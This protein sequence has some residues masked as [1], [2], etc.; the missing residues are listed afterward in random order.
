VPSYGRPETLRDCLDACLGLDPA[1]V[2]L[3]VALRL[4]DVASRKTVARLGASADR[5]PSVRV[6]DVERPGHLPPL[7][8]GIAACSTD[9]I[10][11][12]DDDAVP[13]AGWTGA[14][15]N[16][17]S[18][19]QIVAVTG[20]VVDDTVVRRHSSLLRPSWNGRRPAFG[21]PEVGRTWYGAFRR[22]PEIGETRG[23]ERAGTLA[24][25]NMAGRTAH[26]RAV[27]I[28][29]DLNRGAAVNYE[30]DLALGLQRRGVVAFIPDMI[31]DHHPAP[32]AAG[33]ARDELGLYMRDYTHNLH[34]VAAKHLSLGRLTTF[35]A[36]MAI[37]GQGVSP[38][39][40]RLS[41]AARRTGEP[42]GRLGRDLGDARRAGFAGGLRARRA[43][44]SSAGRCSSAPW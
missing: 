42:I 36:Y 41:A 43:G 40:L 44:K 12:I 23:A 13:R 26:L 22:L 27:G 17:F 11:I 16:A 10:A 28:D 32:R 2:E 6:V 4:E 39:V 5:G 7:A 3:L 15:L 20:P 25:G 19:P 35:C 9:L 31:V 37:V 38:G 34:Y 29:L 8:V 33:P 1:P 14:I 21:R 30:A 18:L 24:G